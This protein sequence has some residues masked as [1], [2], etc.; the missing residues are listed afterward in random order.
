MLIHFK[1]L[2]FSSELQI[3]CRTHNSAANANSLQTTQF[4]Q[5]HIHCKINNSTTNANLLQTTQ[6]QQQ[7]T[8][9]LQTHNSVVNHRFAADT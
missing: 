4:Q 2:N 9:S 7:I 5:R 3:R 6:F 8:N 1:Q